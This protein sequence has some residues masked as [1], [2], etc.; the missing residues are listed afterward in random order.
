MTAIYNKNAKKKATNI[1]I[2]SDLLEKAKQYKINISA[3]VE[4]TLETLIYEYEK[5]NWEEQNRVAI[6]D[7]NKR[8]KEEGL[9]SDHFRSF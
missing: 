9:F 8:V 4:K 5:A 3:N 2:N 1:S 6:D 7:Y